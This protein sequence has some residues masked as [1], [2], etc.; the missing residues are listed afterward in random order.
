MTW[1]LLNFVLHRICITLELIFGNEPHPS[2]IFIKDL[3]WHEFIN[4]YKSCSTS[5]VVFFKLS[6]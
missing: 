5:V 3:L 6:L 1:N 4:L 2:S